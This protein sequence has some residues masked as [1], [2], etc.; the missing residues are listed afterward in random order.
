MVT[1]KIMNLPSFDKCTI[2]VLGL[3]YVGLPLAVEFAKCSICVS[4]NIKL[5]RK[6]IGFD[7]NKTRI[8]ELKNNFDK[9][10]EFKKEELENLKEIIFTNDEELICDADVYIIT[11]PTPID[12]AKIPFLG[13]L[14]S[15]SKI[16]GEAIKKRKENYP[17]KSNPVIVY[18]STVYPGATEE[19]CI[20]KLRRFGFDSKKIFLWI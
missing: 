13:H 2:A 3:G 9:T 14:K 20:M 12:K 11:V 1:N 6:V 10:K 19:V 8:D 7:I 15:A 5:S 17:A 4:S 18:E 16:V